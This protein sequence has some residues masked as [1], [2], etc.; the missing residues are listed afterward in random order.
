MYENLTIED[1]IFFN[2][3]LSWNSYDKRDFLIKK[4]IKPLFKKAWFKVAWMTLRRETD[5]FYQR[6]TIQSSSYNS[7]N[8][9][10]FYL[11]IDSTPKIFYELNW[12]ELP[13][14]EACLAF[15]RTDKII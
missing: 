11:N 14:K 1:K 8:S 13:I 5:D 15:I 3:A 9:L 10:S 2:K 6:I 12:L 7:D 4:I